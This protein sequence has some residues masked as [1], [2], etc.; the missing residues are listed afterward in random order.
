MAARYARQPVADETSYQ[1]KL[2]KTQDYLQPDMDVLEFACG[3]GSTALVQAKFVKSIRAIDVSEKML[4]IAR[5]KAKAAG[6]I[7]VSFEV[8][9]IEDFAA[10]GQPYDA[11]FGHSILHLLDDKQAV[12]E[13]VFELLRPGGIFVS[14][15]V[16][17]GESNPVLRLL[18]P[19]MR[20]LGLAPFVGVFTP[21][22]LTQAIEAAGF[23]ID[24]Q[25]Q[26]GRGKAV[27]I[28]AKKPG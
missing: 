23:V 3:T 4:E 21:Q 25:W 18:L 20:V 10:D 2:K 14:S 5:E 11:I 15:T 27:F 8:A 7:N 6:V 26:S 17:I 12:L 28:V 19:A 16:C 24:H 22:Q 1:T 9:S 13:K